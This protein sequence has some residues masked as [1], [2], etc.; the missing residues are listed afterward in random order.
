MQAD[1][2][3]NFAS[4]HLLE[5][6]QA[7]LDYLRA[8]L[9]GVADAGPV[10]AA[11]SPPEA[12]STGGRKRYIARVRGTVLRRLGRTG[13][14]HPLRELERAFQLQIAFI[15][16][17][18][19]VPRRLLAWLAQDGDTRLQRR[20]RKVIDHYAGR[21]ARIIGRARQQG[22]V[23]ADVEPQAAARRLIRIIQGLTLGIDA[24]RREC[25][26]AEAV[27]AYA[28]YRTELVS[29]WPG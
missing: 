1:R 23:R 18:P 5:W 29:P 8:N 13:Q 20:V 16:R 28:R 10:E 12:A 17:H 14:A 7:T 26:L 24:E 11:W 6:W 3:N 25:L 15:A 9:D 21:L 2:G 27:K 4:A 22:L 19:E